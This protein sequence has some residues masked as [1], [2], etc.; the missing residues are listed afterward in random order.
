MK[1]LTKERWE[2]YENVKVYYICKKIFESKYLKNKKI[3][4]S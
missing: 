1:L 3:L 4:W 2:S